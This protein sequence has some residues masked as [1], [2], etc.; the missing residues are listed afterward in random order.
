MRLFFS[1]T[2]AAK[3]GFHSQVPFYSQ[4][5]FLQIGQFE[6]PKKTIVIKIRKD[7][8]YSQVRFCGHILS[9]HRKNTVFLIF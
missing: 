5:R 2:R 4:V 3:F 9:L 1:G 7:K 6:H 8:T